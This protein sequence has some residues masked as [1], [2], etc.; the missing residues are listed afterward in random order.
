[1]TNH[2]RQN[3]GI[4][5]DQNL[6]ATNLRLNKRG[7]IQYST[8]HGETWNNLSTAKKW[9]NLF[10][11]PLG[12]IDGDGVSDDLLGEIE[13]LKLKME[14]ASGV[15]AEEIQNLITQIEKLEQ[16]LNNITGIPDE[17]ILALFGKKA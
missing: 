9:I 11:A 5:D 10:T 16:S 3:L 15:Q 12:D 1:M 7:Q 8:D 17:Q 13:D 6:D 4:V 2:D 14:D